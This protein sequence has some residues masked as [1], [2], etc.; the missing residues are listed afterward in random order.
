MKEIV[1]AQCWAHTR[2][3]FVEAQSVEPTLVTQ[4]LEQIGTL[5]ALEA[6]GREQKVIEDTKLHH[7][8]VHAQPVVEQFFAWLEQTVREVVLLPSTPFRHAAQYAL[9]RRA[10]LVEAALRQ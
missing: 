5:Y 3:N 6:Q 8:L 10:A 9:D 4:A 2:R 7:R 1:H